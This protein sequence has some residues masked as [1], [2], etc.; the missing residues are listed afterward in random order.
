LAP[1]FSGGLF[2]FDVNGDFGPDYYIDAATNLGP[3]AV[4]MPLFTNDA[5]ASLPFIWTDLINPNTSRQYY[6]IRLGP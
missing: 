1:A 4:W 2:T 6:R 5:P 3:T